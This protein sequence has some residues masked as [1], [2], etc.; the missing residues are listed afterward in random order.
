MMSVT[1]WELSVLTQLSNAVKLYTPFEVSI[2]DHC[3][4][5]K[6]QNLV[7]PNVTKGN[8]A[9]PLLAAKL[10][11]SPNR[12]AG[13]GTLTPEDE[14]SPVAEIELMVKGALLGFVSVNAVAEEV[15]PTAWLPKLA[16]VGDRV[17]EAAPTPVPERVIDWGELAA[18][19]AINMAAD[20]APVD[21]GLNWMLKVQ[22]A[23]AAMVNGG[24]TPQL[25]VWV[26]SVGLVPT[27]EMEVIVK[28]PVP[29]LVRVADC[30]ADAVPT[31]T[32]P[33]A[34]L[35]GAR[36]TAG[37]VPVPLRETLKFDADVLTDTVPAFALAESGQ[38][39][40]LSVQDGVAPPVGV[41]T[42]PTAQV[43]VPPN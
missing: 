8:G 23:P 40:R 13:I 20:L 14:K 32:L 18:L 1:P 12:V 25:L 11:C 34:K 43:P 31:V 3:T 30:V 26:N 39:F 7:A 27:M 5:F 16:L 9:L 33:N 28:G 19:S 10:S 17:G 42:L 38:N 4:L 6:S 21:K 29:E 24:V 35:V 22:P 2:S 36:V 37:V 15:V 41:T